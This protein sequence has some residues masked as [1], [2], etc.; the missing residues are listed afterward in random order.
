MRG[1]RTGMDQKAYCHALNLIPQLGPVRINR[2]LKACGSAREVWNAPEPR[3][4]AVEGFGEKLAAQVVAVRA[5]IDPARAWQELCG[6]GFGAVAQDEYGYP[7]LLREIYDPP[8]LLYY[9]GDLQV[10]QK[11]CLA[12][13]GSRRHTAYGREIAY[14]FAARLAA[15]GITVVSGLARGIDTWAH[16][17]ALKVKG[18]TAAVLGCGLDIC[19]PP[20]NSLLMQSIRQQGVVLSEFPPGSE[21]LPANFP[22]RNRLISGLSLG[23]VVVEAGEKSGALITASFALEQGREVFAVPG[24]I[25]S[26]C[27]RGCHYLIKEGAKLVDGVESILEEFPHEYFNRLRVNI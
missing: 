16:R 27:S 17:G 12:V 7:P 9:S 4:A 24:S 6:K 8:P 13:V 26:P 19:Y 20:E 25:T 23:T 2:L 5:R 3:L 11:S 14:K 22:R 18:T 21:P 15:C 1:E 10:L